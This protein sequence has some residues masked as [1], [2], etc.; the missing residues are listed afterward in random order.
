MTQP[1]A[2]QSVSEFFADVAARQP[3][4][5]G[6]AVAGAAGALAGALGRMVAAYSVGAKGLEDERGTIQAIAGKL[7]EAQSR[8]LELADA[9]AAAYARLSA[10]MKLDDTDPAKSEIGAASVE[11]ASVP[12]E[13]VRASC[14]VLQLADELAPR[15]N[16]WLRSDLAITA[17]LASAAARAASWMVETN[18][19]GVREHAGEEEAERLCAVCGGELGVGASRLERVLEVC[20]G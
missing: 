11:A 12:L 16:T 18:L 8:L 15:S 14:G 2:D 1:I 20:R 19:P 7:A 6:G 5:G 9:D 4:P 3:S 10:L 17:I 13:I